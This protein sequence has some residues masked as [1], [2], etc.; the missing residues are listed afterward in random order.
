MVRERIRQPARMHG[1][2][3]LRESDLD[4]RSADILVANL[5]YVSLRALPS[6]PRAN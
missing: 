5:K 4:P 6:K 3:R 2:L 1:P